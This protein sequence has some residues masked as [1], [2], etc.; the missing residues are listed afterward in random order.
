VNVDFTT[1]AS[2]WPNANIVNCG[3]SDS[4][5]G[6]RSGWH[7][8]HTDD[9]SRTLYPC[10]TTTIVTDPLT[11]TQA[12]LQTVGAGQSS[13]PTQ[14][15][16]MLAFPM[17][18]PDGAGAP[19]A[20]WLPNEYMVVTRWHLD[21]IT[22]YQ[23]PN[24]P[25]CNFVGGTGNPY[26]GISPWSPGS[27]VLDHIDNDD[28]EDWVTGWCSHIDIWP[29]AGGGGFGYSVHCFPDAMIIDFVNAYHTVAALYTSDE[30]TAHYLC[31]WI[32]PN[33]DYTTGFIGCGG[34]ALSSTQMY[35]DR[36]HIHL[37]N[38]VC[39]PNGGTCLWPQNMWIA[40]YQIWGCAN[41]GTS[42]GCPGTIVNHWP[43]P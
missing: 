18:Y 27:T 39:H 10:N 25:G 2:T 21:C 43:Y 13:S 38:T 34:G 33:A 29:A 5:A 22:R 17:N 24:A 20:P 3:A 40:S 32:D 30:S 37:M 28:I 23:Q 16:Q 41:V 11:G 19:S 4:V 12:L 15:G 42:S 36:G 1:V 31:L 7:F 6:D 14:P 35:T 26:G 9:F 8:Y